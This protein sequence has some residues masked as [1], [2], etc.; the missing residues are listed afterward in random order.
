MSGTTDKGFQDE[1]AKNVVLTGMPGCGKTVLGRLAARRLNKEFIDLDE[2]IE[3]RQGVS[4]K[5]IFEEFGEERFRELETAAAKEVSKKSGIVI[6]PGGGVVLK[7][8]NIDALKQTGAII[9][10]FRPVKLI[11][12][13]LR[14]TES[15]PLLKDFS[16][17]EIFAK[18]KKLYE[19]SADYKVLNF[20][21]SAALEEIIQIYENRISKPL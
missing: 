5:E 16:L 2:F 1:N 8:E 20:D 17:E 7:K 13:S 6:S 15:R 14:E 4:V 21:L 12:K 3:L 9:Y 19:T 10:I 18:R 11:L